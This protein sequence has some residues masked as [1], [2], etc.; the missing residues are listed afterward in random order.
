MSVPKIDRTTPR[1][2]FKVE[3]DAVELLKAT[4]D[5]CKNEHIV[6]KRLRFIYTKRMIDLAFNVLQEINRANRIFLDVH[7]A[8]ERFMLQSKVLGDLDTL[9]A[10][11]ELLHSESSFDY[12]KKEIW[13]EKLGTL[14][15]VLKS[16]QTSDVLR[17]KDLMK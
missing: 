1:A 6:P 7:S 11:I 15:A 16:W 5:F 13:L 9:A 12:K 4:K 3:A 2:T 8:N 14:A 17:F 10:L